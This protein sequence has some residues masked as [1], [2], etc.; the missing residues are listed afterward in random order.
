MIFKKGKFFLEKLPEFK[1]II[2][3]TLENKIISKE[4]QGDTGNVRRVSSR[5]RS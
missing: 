3:H 2:S 1:K 5:Q 4:N